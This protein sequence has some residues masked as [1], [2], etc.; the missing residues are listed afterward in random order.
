MPLAT[1]LPMT[2]EQAFDAAEK[3]N[4]QVTAAQF[5]AQAAT[6]RVASARAGYMPTVSARASLGYDAGELNGSGN[7]FKDYD[8]SVSGGLTA[9]IPLFTGGLTTSQVRAAS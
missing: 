7:Q 9:S 2:V 6:A 8:R 3:N 4:P 1:Q 5:S